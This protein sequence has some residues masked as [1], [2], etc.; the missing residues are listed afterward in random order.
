M[1]EHCCQTSFTQ[2]SLQEVN[3]PLHSTVDLV[4]KLLPKCTLSC[5]CAAQHSW[6]YMSSTSRRPVSHLQT[7]YSS[8]T[9]FEFGL[10]F[11]LTWF[12]CLRPYD[13]RGTGPD[14]HQEPVGQKRP[15]QWH[16]SPVENVARCICYRS[17]CLQI[18]DWWPDQVRSRTYSD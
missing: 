12:L 1:N 6:P 9:L 5:F 14:Y 16:V 17:N 2:L 7:D 18:D 13:G 15:Q 10:P 8:F 3:T 11:E 4:T